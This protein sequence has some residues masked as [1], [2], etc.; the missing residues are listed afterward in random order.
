MFDK[1]HKKYTH[2]TVFGLRTVNCNHITRFGQL[3]N[4]HLYSAEQNEMGIQATK[5]EKKKRKKEK[6]E[7]EKKK[8]KKERRRSYDQNKTT[9]IACDTF[10]AVYDGTKCVLPMG[11]PAITCRAPIPPPHPTPTPEKMSNDKAVKIIMSLQPYQQA[12]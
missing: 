8:R 3:H 5:K 10:E 12:A 4:V 9:K 6:K 2:C 1:D 7:E 11:F